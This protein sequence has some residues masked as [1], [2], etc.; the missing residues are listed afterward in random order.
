MDLQ[1]EEPK[2]S[3]STLNMLGWAF[4]CIVTLALFFMPTV[5]L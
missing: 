1:H 5:N 3:S 2:N 4:V